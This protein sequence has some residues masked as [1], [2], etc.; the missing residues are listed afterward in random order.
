MLLTVALVTLLILIQYTYFFMRT[1]MARGKDT[2]KAPATS[3]DEAYERKLRVQMNTLEQMA[4]TLPSMW[5]CAHFFRADVAAILGTVFIVG[6]AIY[7][8]SYIKDPSKR[9]PGFGIG[10]LANTA[11]IL[12]SLYGVI[13][14]LI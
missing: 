6:R 13:S 2:V 9:G 10:F 1:G 7:S 5:L 11:L 3:G 12:A 8:S 14:Q 4:I